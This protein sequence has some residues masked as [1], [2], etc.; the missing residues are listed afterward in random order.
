MRSN[1][2]RVREQPEPPSALWRSAVYHYYNGHVI[3][4]TRAAAQ[5][6]QFDTARPR[7]A[8]PRLVLH[9]PDV[10]DRYS[11]RR[12][13]GRRCLVGSGR[14]AVMPCSAT[15]GD[16]DATRY[17]GPLVEVIREE[18]TMSEIVSDAYRPSAAAALQHRTNE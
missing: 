14:V 2:G 10:T 18:P 1:G 13:A 4:I 12:V 16:A 8:L 7:P 9:A 6:Y 5:P 3:V 15:Q 17:D 11:C